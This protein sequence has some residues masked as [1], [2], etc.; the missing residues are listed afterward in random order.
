MN[1]CA[2]KEAN[3]ADSKLSGLVKKLAAKIS[4]ESRGALRAAERAWLDYRD[5][6]CAFNTLASEGGSVHDLVL[7]ACL[8][9]LTDKQIKQVQQQLNCGQGDLGCG[10]Q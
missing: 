10:G 7:A 5:K 1:I 8:K 9:D 6:Q 4:P 2:G 3:D